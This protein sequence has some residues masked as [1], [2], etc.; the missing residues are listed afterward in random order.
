M[1]IGELKERL[2]DYDNHLPVKVF[3]QD[4]YY[5]I[6]VTDQSDSLVNDGAP[7]IGIFATTDL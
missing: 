3:R 4:R 1:T 6:D 2:D 5:D 7:F